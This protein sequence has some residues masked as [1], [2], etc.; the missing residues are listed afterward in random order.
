M[1]TED[2]RGCGAGRAGG[3]VSAETGKVG[4]RQGSP[5]SSKG[6]APGG[7]TGYLG[8]ARGVTEADYGD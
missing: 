7:A 3:S 2:I 6:Q 1:T 8:A 5:T 4:D